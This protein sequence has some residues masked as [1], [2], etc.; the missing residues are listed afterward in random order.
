MVLGLEAKTIF[1]IHDGYMIMD[2]PHAAC[3]VLDY[4]SNC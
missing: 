2:V 4:R 1:A 3:G